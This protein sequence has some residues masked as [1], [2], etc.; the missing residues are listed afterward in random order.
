MC[1]IAGFTGK[2]IQHH[3]KSEII[4][5]M[6]RELKFR[7]PDSNGVYTNSECVLGHTRLSVIDLLSGNQPMSDITG[8]YTIVYNGEVYNYQ[9]LK[10]RL[11][12]K[13]YKF[14][15][16][17]DTEVIVYLFADKGTK[18]FNE[19]DG[20]FACAIWDNTKKIL[21]LARDRFG[22]K[23]LYYSS[24]DN[25]KTIFFASEIKSLLIS[26]AVKGLVNHKAIDAYL[27]LLYVPPSQNIYNNIH[28]LPPAHYMQV[29]ESSFTIS[30]YWKLKYRPI[31]ISYEEAQ[32]QLKQLMTKAVTKRLVSDVPIGTFLSGGLDSTLVTGL[33]KQ[34]IGHPIKSFSVGFGDSINE[35]PYAKS[36]AKQYE[37]EHVI[38]NVEHNLTDTIIRVAQYFDEPFADSSS[39]PTYLLSK[40]TKSHVT[41]ALS[42]DG[43][44]EFFMGY[45]W[46]R[47]H[48]HIPRMERIWKKISSNPCNEYLSTIPYL[49]PINRKRLWN[50]D[51]LPYI[52]G[53]DIFTESHNPIRKINDY[54]I[55][56]YLVGDILTKVDRASMMASLEVRSPFLD[57][58]LCEFAYNIPV[59]YK[60]T[61]RIGKRIIKDAFRDIIPK[62]I[63][64][65]K[66]QGFGA[67]VHEW[68]KTPDCYSLARDTLTGETTQLYALFNKSEI[69]SI[70]KQYGKHPNHQTAYRIWILLVLELWLEKYSI[71][72][73]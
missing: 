40:E 44:D 27:T 32:T 46:Y 56:N 16:N 52:P 13:G 31:N 30:R 73:K 57:W 25:N 69:R 35:L 64:G 66:K 28:S 1:G 71:Y 10:K 19:L 65:R 42:G 72:H 54:D 12:N 2:N 55:N 3:V 33:A 50:K 15:T 20:M 70:I 6:I 4:N 37:V 23:P 39:V 5:D 38:L 9:E 24:P 67:P 22:Q 63:I 68:L 17:S 45:K 14:K 58:Q 62:D 18:A 7:G 53:E 36:A 61:K 34:N 60:Q 47:R 48:H 59:K 49:S 43:A 41:V 11:L 26:G 21:T 8:R 29:R 51:M